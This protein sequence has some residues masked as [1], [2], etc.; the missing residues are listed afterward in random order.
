MCKFFI[1]GAYP[2]C[3]PVWS[4]KWK[5]DKDHFCFFLRL[6]MFKL[7]H[8]HTQQCM[9]QSKRYKQPIPIEYNR[10][11]G[12]NMISFSDP[13][14]CWL[15][16]Q[17]PIRL[18]VSSRHGQIGWSGKSDFLI[19]LLKGLDLIALKCLCVHYSTG[20]G[21]LNNG[22]G[23]QELFLKLPWALLTGTWMSIVKWICK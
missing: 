13:L 21:F 16:Y 6:E 3:K 14:P 23:N 12:A 15:V 1:V 17:T 7:V 19:F 2:F 10:C 18:L 5:F 22:L 11:K 20:E 4:G 8:M 9:V